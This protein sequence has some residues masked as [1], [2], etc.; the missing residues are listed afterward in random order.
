MAPDTIHR[1]RNQTSKHNLSGAVAGRTDGEFRP[2]SGGGTRAARRL[3]VH[4]ARPHSVR[5]PHK[6][7][8]AHVVV[9]HTGSRR[10]AG[11]RLAL[12]TD[13]RG[14]SQ[15]GS[16]GNPGQVHL[17]TSGQYWRAKR[18]GKSCVRARTFKGSKDRERH[19]LGI[20]SQLMYARYY[21]TRRSNGGTEFFAT[22]DRA[23]LV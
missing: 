13:G 17:V 18:E 12:G 20:L 8:R 11:L 1:W 6:S 14:Q 10:V 23:G 22:A 4:V 15:A 16:H 2:V 7:S 5:R 19:K 9:R 3:V 21:T